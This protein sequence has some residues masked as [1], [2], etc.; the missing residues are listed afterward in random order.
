MCYGIWVFSSCRSLLKST[1][2][3]AKTNIFGVPRVVVGKEAIIDSISWPMFL[4]FI[5][6]FAAMESASQRN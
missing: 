6:S 4:S 1:G 2:S 5:G 3:S